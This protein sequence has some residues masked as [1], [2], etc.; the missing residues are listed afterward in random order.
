MLVLIELTNTLSTL[1]DLFGVM[2][3]VAEEDQL[4]SLDLEIESAVNTCEGL[5]TIFQFLFGAAIKLCHRHCGNAVF[6]VDGD[7]L[8]EFD[9]GDILDGRDEVEIDFPV[10]DADILC[11]EVAFVET[12][13][14]ATDTLL[15][16]LLH[17]KTTMDNQGTTW[18][19]QFC[20]MAETLQISLFGAIDVEVVGVGRGDDAHP[21]VEPMERAVEL[22]GLD[23]HVIGVREDI[24]GAVVL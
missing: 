24:V 11:M 12:V 18:L 9:V 13:V 4:I 7:G 22:I 15:Q 14:I 16:V 19:D 8:S 23:D 21:G 17:L 20:I 3:V 10:A 5:H 2:G 1:I 6:D